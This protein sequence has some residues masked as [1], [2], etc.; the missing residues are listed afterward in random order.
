MNLT[1]AIFAPDYSQSAQ[2][3]LDAFIY[4]AK[5]QLGTFGS[6]DWDCSSWDISETIQRAS[7][8]TKVH[9]NWTTIDTTRANSRKGSKAA[10]AE[11]M[12]EPFSDFAKAFIRYRYTHKPTSII[13]GLPI[14]ALRALERALYESTGGYDVTKIDARV[15]NHAAKLASRRWAKTAWH[16][17]LYL[18]EIADQLNDLRL[19]H[20]RFQWKTRA[21]RQPETSM[22]RT[23]PEA[24]ARRSRVLPSQTALFAS[25]KAFHEAVD[26]RDVLVASTIAL[27]VCAPDRISEVLFM[28]EDSEV[29]KSL[30]GKPSYGFRWF[31]MKGGKP[32]LKEIPSVMEGIARMAYGNLVEVTTSAR[33]MAKWY[34]KNPNRLYLPEDLEHLRRQ[35]FL[36]TEDIKS[37]LGV[38]SHPTVLK[39]KKVPLQKVM[40][41]GRSHVRVRFS[42]FEAWVIGQLPRGFPVMNTQRALHYANALFVVPSG[43]FKGQVSRVMFETATWDHI[44]RNLGNGGAGESS[45]FTRMQLHE[46]DGAP[47]RLRTHQFRHWLNTLARKGG[48]SELEI[49]LWSGRKSVRANANYDTLS[50]EEMT[51]L[52]REVMRPQD[53]SLVD[54]IVRGPTRRDEFD[55]LKIKTGH[56]TEFGVCVH[57]YAMAP[58][59]KHGDCINCEEQECV[60]G[61]DASNARIRE[62]LEIAEALHKKSVEALG[63]NWNGAGRWEAHHYRT[64]KRLRNLVA[65]LDDPKVP[66]GSIIRLARGDQYTSLGMALD[67]HKQLTSDERNAKV[68]EIRLLRQGA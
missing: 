66:V 44:H 18:Q 30:D 2:A 64:V 49:A 1:A 68:R 37:L 46:N 16:V 60:K 59:H 38:K 54:Y 10:K 45:I 35:D 8:G 43:F 51:S 65:I 39:Q 33:K 29:H 42:D 47:I 55:V 6:V 5:C 40:Q 11:P 17:G 26:P 24:D 41:D 63:N 15:M 57:D 56:V 3:N 61:D 67:E 4:L 58:C 28:A 19:T 52:S 12:H 9:L 21:V 48:L 32:M 62:A 36:D 20:R 14:L 34:S 7:R 25:A 50:D 22:Y 53:S 27:L 23:G 31:P 13:D